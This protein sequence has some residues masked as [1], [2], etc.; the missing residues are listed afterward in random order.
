MRAPD[1][2]PSLWALMAREDA[3][4]AEQAGLTATSVDPSAN[5][6]SGEGKP[7]A[8]GSGR[9]WPTSQVAQEQLPAAP[10][11]AHKIGF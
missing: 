1:R 2:G 10:V 5:D 3:P 4:P 6:F 8:I 9:A 7:R 11:E